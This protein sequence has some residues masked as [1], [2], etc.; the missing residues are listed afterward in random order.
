MSNR[1]VYDDMH[2]GDVFQLDLGDGRVRIDTIEEMKP[3]FDGPHGADTVV[4][5]L[6]TFHRHAI[7]DSER[8]TLLFAEYVDELTRHSAKQI[9]GA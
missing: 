9:G 2:I 1:S 3:V 4:S 5:F 8:R 7:R 6:S